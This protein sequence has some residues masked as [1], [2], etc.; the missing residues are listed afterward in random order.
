[1]VTIMKYFLCLLLT[2]STNISYANGADWRKS[3]SDEEKLKKIIKVIPSTSDIMFQMGERYKNLYWA[4]KQGK[5]DFAEYQLE[6]M[7]SLLKTLMITRPK[8]K[9]TARNFLD[10]GFNGYEDAIK[11]KDWGA[12]QK[13]FNNMRQACEHCHKQ[14]RHAFITLQKTPIKG[15]SP[16]LD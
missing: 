11:N 3:G 2:L 15:S 4:A 10:Y 12:F 13:T 6:E 7:E 5:W 8:R 1:M 14:N 16:V 9:E